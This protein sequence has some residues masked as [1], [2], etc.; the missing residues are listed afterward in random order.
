MSRAKILLVSSD[1]RARDGLQE[2]L[3][4][5]N[6]DVVPAISAAEAQLA[7]VRQRFDTL[8]TELCVPNPGD[9]FAVVTAMRHSQPW[10]TTVAVDD[11]GELS[12]S[13]TVE[14]DE[15]LEKPIDVKHLIELIRPRMRRRN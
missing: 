6:F 10:A 3:E 1:V 13:A 14:A 4:H 12:A 7:I 5:Y 15:V 8:I 2:V 11:M 9:G